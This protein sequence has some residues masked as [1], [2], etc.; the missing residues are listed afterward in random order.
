[1]KIDLSGNWRI[2]LEDGKIN[3]NGFLPGTLDENKMGNPDKVAR[4]WHPDV[5]ER[6]KNLEAEEDGDIRIATRL[7]RNYTYEGCATFTKILKADI[8]KDKRYF[9]VAERTRKM[10]L[11]IDG[12]EVPVSESNLCGHSYVCG[13]STPW[14]FEVTGLI[15]D[16]SK[17]EISTDNTYPGWPYKDITYSS[18]ATDETQTNWNGVVGELYLEERSEAFIQEV[19]IIPEMDMGGTISGEVHIS[20]ENLTQ[21]KE[22]NSA[23][24]QYRK[25]V[26]LEI[27]GDCLIEP[28]ICGGDDDKTNSPYMV[29]T[30]SNNSFVFGAIDLSQKCRESRWDEYEGNLHTL[31]ARLYAGDELL[32]E[33][34]VVFG[35]RNFGYDENEHLTIN[36]R[37]I[38]LRSEANC[39]LFPETG[40]PP[41]DKDSWLEIMKTYA[42]YG[43]NCVRFHSWCPPEAAFVAADELGMMVQPELPNWNPRDAF[44]SEESRDFYENEL[45][46]IVKTYTNHPSF[47]MLTLGNELHTD[48]DGI[49]EMHRLMEIA[50]DIDPTKLYAWGSNNFYGA[51][52]TDEESDFY[53]SSNCG[54]DVLRLAM[55]GN[56]GRINTEQPNTKRNFKE[57]MEKI[58]EDYKKPFFSFEVGQYEV[59]PDMHELEQFEG[60]TR[61]DNF[62]IV[63][64]RQRAA[65]LSDE[66]YEKRVSATGEMALLAYREEVE[67]VMRTSQMS[68]ISLLGLQDFTGQGT[69]LVG[70][71]NSHLRPKEYPFAKP[72]RFKEFFKD[73]A[74]LV[75]MD[76][77]IYEVGETLRAEIVVVNYG[78]KD[79]PGSFAYELS[80]DRFSNRGGT[81][82]GGLYSLGVKN[83]DFRCPVGGLTSLGFIDIYFDNIRIPV[84]F[85]L[86]IR[87][88]GLG[89]KKTA[90]VNSE[91]DNLYPIW[92]YPKISPKCP[93]DVYET[94]ILDDKAIK[95]LEKGGKV[96]YSPDSTAEAIPNSIK[97]QF[98][99]DFWS[100]GTFPQQEG[101]MGQLIDTEHPLFRY[102]PTQ[103]YTNWQ[104]FNMASQRAF[105]MPRYMKTIITEMDCYVTLRPMAQLF[106]A[107]CGHGKILMS[108]MGLQNLQQYP[109]ARALLDSIYNYMGSSEFKPKETLT[110]DELAVFSNVK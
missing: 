82:N 47:V 35:L 11:K 65:G 99:T 42:S 43:V 32:D 72:Y 27:T 68:G 70:M 76:K 59:L 37:R 12:K 48:A 61:P 54:E 53:T 96:Y 81:I 86:K 40:H 36:G 88:A 106:E 4:A 73:Q 74:V 50:R 9:L 45:K 17:I 87:V 22:K 85:T 6:N 108:S 104:W 2:T 109:E 15:H 41:M 49:E 25:E 34:E 44:S 64:D 80:C 13:L 100:V 90:I 60:V 14:E 84:Q 89:E 103:E 5:E 63:R 71:M 7:T 57:S 92:V 8:K 20:Y 46:Q 29:F 1:M 102:F 101:A 51:K 19:L 21:G 58:L 24:G 10:T 98:S 105:I 107:R 110:F 38:F 31:T 23:Q 33:K 97:A 67:A 18:A 94:G 93:E 95:V 52:G 62:L 66:E 30:G 39:G 56:N 69:A 83:N 26:R 28:I 91:V 55:A 78:K 77:Y 75:L 79:L 16:E 3:D